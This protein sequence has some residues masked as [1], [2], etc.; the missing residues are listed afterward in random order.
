MSVRCVVTGQTESGKSVFVRDAEAEPI[1]LS[2]LPGFEFYRYQ[3]SRGDQ[4]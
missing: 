3:S 1:T 4:G 2:L